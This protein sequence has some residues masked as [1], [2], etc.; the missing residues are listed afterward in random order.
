MRLD[1]LPCEKP[2]AFRRTSRLSFGGYAAEAK[3][4]LFQGANGKHK[5]FRTGGGPA[6]NG[7]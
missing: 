4:L 6:A 3:P 1:R 5:A 7:K 2:L